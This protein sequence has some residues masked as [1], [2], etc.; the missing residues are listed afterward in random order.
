MGGGKDKHDESDKGL[1]S[2][3]AHGVAG[4]PP[5]QYPPPGGYPPQQGYPPQGYPPH[6][7]GYPPQG[8]GY[9][10]H[11][12][13][14]PPQ[15]YPPAGYPPAPGAYPPG[16]YPGGSSHTGHSGMILLTISFW[17]SCGKNKVLIELAL[18]HFMLIFY[19]CATI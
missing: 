16:G 1:F 11:G 9:P 17:M 13:G 5:G 14:Y 15:A 8:G 2:H 7:G 6:G 4:Y 10:P 3:L 18:V 19:S 12:G